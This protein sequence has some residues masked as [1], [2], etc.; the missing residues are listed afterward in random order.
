MRGWV[1]HLQLLL[2]LASAT[3]LRPESCGTH[4]ILLFQIQDSLNLKG[5]VPVF[6]SPRDRVSQLQPQELGS[7]FV[8][9]YNLQGSSGGI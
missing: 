9:S 8:A 7:F 1:C 5:H 4:H 2:T 6:I 3:I